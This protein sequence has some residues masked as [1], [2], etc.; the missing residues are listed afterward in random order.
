M[1]NTGERREPEK[2]TFG[3]PLLPIKHPHKTPPQTNLK[4]GGGGPP[5]LPPLNHLNPH[6][7]RGTVSIMPLLCLFIRRKLYRLHSI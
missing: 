6:M 2:T 5:V 7:R 1:Y 3:H 4:R